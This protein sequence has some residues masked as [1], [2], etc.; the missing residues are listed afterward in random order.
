MIDMGLYRRFYR[1]R[2][3]SSSGAG[4]GAICEVSTLSTSLSTNSNNTLRAPV[5]HRP[6]KTFCRRLRHHGV[7]MEKI[8][9]SDI[10]TD[11]A[12]HRPIFEEPSDASVREDP[13]SGPQGFMIGGM[14]LPTLNELS[15]QYFD[16]A[17]LLIESIK[18]QAWEDYKLVNPAL[19]LYRH[20]LELMV[21]S[22]IGK[23][24]TH[25]LSKLADE[26]NSLAVT[27]G[28]AAAPSWIIKRLKEIAL[29]DPGATA[30]R[31]AENYNNKQKRDIPVDGEIYINLNHLQRAMLTLYTAL[32]GNLPPIAEMHPLQ[33]PLSDT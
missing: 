15:Q 26:L 8:M 25:D 24:K 23:V 6:E 33:F 20:A 11:E 9:L 14:S 12:M 27:K 21:K 19:F 13:W 1:Q 3:T 10:F 2:H 29:I 28:G 32:S 4:D 17:H 16:A 22:L 7:S 5:L 18:N 30:F 31:Y